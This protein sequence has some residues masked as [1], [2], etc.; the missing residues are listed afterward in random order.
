MNVFLPGAAGREA[1]PIDFQW[2]GVGL[3]MVDVGMHLS[4]SVSPAALAR[5]GERELV[6]FYRGALVEALAVCP[7]VGRSL[8]GSLGPPPPP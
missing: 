8:P 6:E 5:G 4:H 1:L 2:T 3:G 7:G